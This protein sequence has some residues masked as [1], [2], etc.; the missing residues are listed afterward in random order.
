M[1][2]AIG[3]SA[4][5]VT[6]KKRRV[7]CRHIQWDDGYDDFVFVDGGVPEM[8]VGKLKECPECGARRPRA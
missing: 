6:K 4:V 8:T 1:R 3:G 2:E 7:W 5:K